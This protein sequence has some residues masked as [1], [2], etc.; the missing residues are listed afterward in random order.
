[1]S[2]M[3]IIEVIPLTRGS[4]I[5][6]LTYYSGTAYD[7]GSIIEVP[8]RKSTVPAMVTGV[9]PLSAARNAL[10][11]ATFSLKKLPAELSAQPLPPSLIETAKLLCASHPAQLGAVLYALLPP[12]VRDGTQ[13]TQYTSAVSHADIRPEIEVL[14]ATYDDRFI[15]YRSKIREVF[16][17]SGSVLFVVPTAADIDRVIE[18]LSS[19]IENRVVI[20]SPHYTKKKM[21]ASYEAF[22][23]LTNAKLIITT[24]RHAYLD[25]HDIMH[26]I[27]EQSRSR[28]YKSKVRPYLDHRDVL[29]ALAQVT[30]RTTTYGDI[31]PRSEDEY[32]RREDIYTTYGEAPKRLPF[33]SR[34]EIIKQEEEPSAEKP[35]ELFTPQLKKELQ[36]II[37]ARGRS[38][39]YAARRGIAPVVICIDCGHIFRCPDSGAPY[40]LFKTTHNGE[41]QRWF[42][43]QASGKRVR[44]ADTCSACG[45]WRLRER[46][47]GIQHIHT[48]L[49]AIFPNVPIFLFDHTTATTY[50]KAK[51]IIG[52]FYDTKGSILL[53]TQMVLPYIDTPV[54]LTAVTSLDATRSIPSWRAEE[55]FYGLLLTLRERSTQAVLI[56]TRTEPDEILS[57]A[58][59]GLVEQFYTDEL[60][61]R[62][63]LMYPPFSTFILLTWQDTKESVTQTE[64]KLEKLLREYKPRFYSAPQSLVKKTTRY[65]LMRIERSQWPLT[66]LVT[67]L[68]ALPPSIKIEINPDRIV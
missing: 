19:G 43:S 42:L 56:Q 14:Q 29:K 37:D 27:V 26:I 58:K 57:Y 30:N 24:P 48:E 16:A 59:Q 52:K 35:F 9:K 18:T 2:Y 36:Q 51:V 23:D 53:G 4:Y 21:A 65:G 45:S 3:Y 38:F 55:E 67:I 31:L 8:L 6:S 47:I 28:Y 10:R 60:E 54:D 20:F 22:Y 39:V 12:E 5:D 34:F 68:R 11:A 66:E 25:R 15:A 13:P 40:S 44:A 41:E 17:H 64:A 50:K 61:L 62:E 7:T 1:M 33:S 63:A 46:G 49:Q 32:L